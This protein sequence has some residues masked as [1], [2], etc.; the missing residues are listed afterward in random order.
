MRV[1]PSIWHEI[2][3]CWWRLSTADDRGSRARDQDHA[4]RRGRRRAPPAAAADRARSQHPLRLPPPGRVARRRADAARRDERRPRRRERRGLP[5]RDRVEL[6]V[7]D[8]AGLGRGGGRPDLSRR[9]RRPRPRARDDRGRSR[10]RLDGARHGGSSPDQ[11]RHRLGAPHRAVPR[12]RPDARPSS[13]GR[14]RGLRRRAERLAFQTRCA[15]P[16]RRRSASRE[17]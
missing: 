5:R 3:V 2:R 17:P 14:G 9:D 16:P 7:R 12:L 4:A 1:A 15:P 11:R 8:A 6:R 10:R 13:E